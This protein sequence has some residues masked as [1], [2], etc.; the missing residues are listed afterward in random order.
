[1][2]WEPLW[3]DLLEDTSP[4]DWVVE[5]LWPAWSK[6][7]NGDI[8]VRVGAFV[9]EGFEAYA[10]VFHPAY[11]RVDVHA[12]WEDVRWS[13]VASWNGRVVH[14]EMQFHRIA[15]LPDSPTYPD[16]GW[17]IRPMR[18]YLPEREG[19][20][21]VEELKE[22]TSTPEICYFCIWEGYGSV[23]GHDTNARVNMNGKSY[24][25]FRGPLSAEGSYIGRQSP[26]F[27][28]SPNIWWPADRAWCVA[29]GIDFAETLVGGSV[30]CIANIIGN[31]SLEALP[32]TLEARMD[33]RADTIN[34]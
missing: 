27:H 11:R 16:P 7:D 32:I 2:P 3:V 10:R 34:S 31:P 28:N 17:G 22:F 25:L 23:D 20:I 6:T 30:A 13:T 21:M 19:Q 1:M 24:L 26:V 9:P 29:T 8:A 14:P 15:N 4:V 12:A 18:G 5:S 33:Y